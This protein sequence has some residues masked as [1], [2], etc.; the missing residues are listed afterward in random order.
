MTK[1]ATIPTQVQYR[2]SKLGEWTTEA[3]AEKHKA[4]TEREVIKHPERRKKKTRR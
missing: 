2:D 4:T 1:K 3:Y